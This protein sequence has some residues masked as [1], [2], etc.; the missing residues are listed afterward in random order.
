MQ[1]QQQQ[2]QQQQSAPDHQVAK[3]T[4]LMHHCPKFTRAPKAVAG[5]PPGEKNTRTFVHLHSCRHHPAAGSSRTLCYLPLIFT[6]PAAHELSP[7]DTR[8]I[9]WSAPEGGEVTSSGGAPGSVVGAGWNSNGTGPPRCFAPLLLLL[10]HLTLTFSS[11]TRPT[12]AS[13]QKKAHTQSRPL[14]HSPLPPHSSHSLS[15]PLSISLSWLLS[16]ESLL[17]LTSRLAR[18]H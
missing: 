5:I 7:F 11:A 10:P 15:A 6:T 12:R 2:Q 17:L 16:S 18:L 13:A 4:S 8:T 14:S 3:C 9:R 1:Q